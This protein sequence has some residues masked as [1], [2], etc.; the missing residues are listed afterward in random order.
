M[1]AQLR[2]CKMVLPSETPILDQIRRKSCRLKGLIK[3]FASWSLVEIYDTMRYPLTTWSHT[4]WKLIAMYFIFEWKGV[5]RKVGSANVVT[6]YSKCLRE[7]KTKFTQK[8]FEPKNFG[9][10]ASKGLI[11]KLRGRLS[12]KHLFANEE[13]TLPSKW[14][15]QIIKK[16]IILFTKKF[17]IK[18]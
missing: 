8:R 14:L 3:A 11:F 16:N 13:I 18:N 9:N 6:I 5:D 1:L 2:H 10:C 12:N 7:L 15:I 4:K 17:L